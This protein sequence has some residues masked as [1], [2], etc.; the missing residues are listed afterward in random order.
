MRKE[1]VPGGSSE[2][3]ETPEETATRESFE[4]TGLSV[5][6]EKLV[7]LYN[8]IVL[9]LDGTEKCRFLHYLFLASTTDTSP[10]PGSEWQDWGATC[11]WIVLKDLSRYRGVWP[12]PEQVR[13]QIAHGNLNL[14][15]LGELKYQME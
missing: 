13:G 10:Q 5:N 11:R 1:V 2:L 6:I 12:L 9:N 3:G 8:L 15:N 14:G 7:A 4:E